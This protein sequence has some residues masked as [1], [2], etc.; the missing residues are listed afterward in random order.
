MEHRA[1]TEAAAG[2]FGGPGFDSGDGIVSREKMYEAKDDARRML[3]G[4]A[5]GD[6]KV[7]VY[8][9]TVPGRTR[10]YVAVPRKDEKRIEA[11][12]PSGYR[13]SAVVER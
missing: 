9:I 12:F 1:D 10:E 3:S 7:Y 8:E 6:R 2:T 13:K 5:S 11:M 4:E